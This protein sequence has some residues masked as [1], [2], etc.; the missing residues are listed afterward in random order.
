MGVERVVRFAPGATPDW[1]SVA[2]R[3]TALG[4]PPAVRMIDGL[5]AF[6]DEQPPADWQEIRLGLAGG[7]V[8]VRRTADGVR[9]VTWG[10]DDP[11]LMRSQ[12]LCFR[13][14]AEASAGTDSGPGGS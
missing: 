1:P 13:A 4:D 11:A 2:A 14:W 10:T 12:D 8:T 7:M 3:L 6:P 9:C 5:P